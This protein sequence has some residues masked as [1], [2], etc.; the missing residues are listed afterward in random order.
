MRV[1]P[2]FSLSI[3]LLLSFTV[4]SVSHAEIYKTVDKNGR[5]IYTDLPPSDTKAKV[6]ELPAINTVPATQQAPRYDSPRQNVE[7]IEYQLAITSPEDGLTMTAGDRSVEISAAS[8]QS[9][10][11]GHLFTFFI[12]GSLIERTSESTIT[13]D[14]PPRGEHRLTV[15]V[16]DEGGNSFGKSESVTLIVIR[17]SLLQKPPIVPPKK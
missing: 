12:D 11:P 8:N 6:V 7:Q 13:L 2:A 16:T 9:L 5:T 15:E 1:S 14:E 3:S 17:P 4:T 10:E